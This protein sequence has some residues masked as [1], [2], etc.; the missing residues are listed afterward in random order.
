MTLPD[1]DKLKARVA[2][3][4]A[5]Q[6]QQAPQQ[7]TAPA[8]AA[9]AGPASR[10][11]AEPGLDDGA[12]AELRRLPLLDIYRRWFAPAAERQGGGDEVNVSCFNTHFHRG[13]DSNPQLGF[14]TAKNTYYCHACG[15]TGDIID[16]AAIRWGFCDA[17]WQCPDSDVHEAVR[18]AGEELLGMAFR[19]TPAGWQR[20]Q[21]VQQSFAM[22]SAPSINSAPATLSPAAPVQGGLVLGM[23]QPPVT[24]MAPNLSN[25]APPPYTGPRPETTPEQGAISST[26]DEEERIRR[27]NF[28]LKWRD[29]VPQG[30]PLWNYMQIASHDD[31]P[32]EF[33][34]WNFMSLIG[35]AMGRKVFIP[36][37]KPVYGNMLLCL[38]GRTGQGKSRSES[39]INELLRSAMPFD[40]ADHLTNGVKV[41]KNPGSGE[42]LA[43]IFKHEVPNPTIPAQR[44]KKPQMLVNPSVK[45]LVRWPEMATM[46]GKSAGKGSIVQT[47]MID[48]YDCPDT[49]GGGSMTNGSYE[50]KNPFGSVTTTTQLSAARR[51]V[52]KDD[53][54]SGFLN[55]W[56][57]VIGRSKEFDPW[58]GHINIA[59]VK[60]DVELLVKWVETKYRTT[61]GWHNL[62]DDARQASGEFLV[63]RAHPLEADENDEM[64][65]RAV[66]TF[67]KLI[68][69]F[70][71]N[72]MEEVV[73]IAAVDQAKVAFEYLVDCMKHMGAR[74]TESDYD[75]AIN[76]VMNMIIDSGAEGVQGRDMKKSL[77]R[78]LKLP[79]EDLDK[80]ISDME[81]TGRIQLRVIPQP[82]GRVGA[83]KKRYFLCDD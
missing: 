48:L 39:Y 28:S 58:G 65:R 31:S 27:A 5:E 69:L 20:I 3:L 30:T 51:L 62:D 19:L 78:K 49:I 61:G 11:D 73:S 7:P 35:L 43:S 82:A 50:A 9:P 36:D 40:E 53:A 52:T 60:H 33:H 57:F 66:L 59:P 63:N 12:K 41:V 80:M 81:K 75:V 54:A 74:I 46:I 77:K 64:L 37:V 38:I 71:A 1:P 79:T 8:P 23:F 72:M 70:S 26:D 25:L 2:E 55:R 4:L 45:A 10:V 29:F 15:V 76:H 18:Y 17:N 47:T 6:A 13:G 56:W 34:F 24:S 16:L 83:P 21:P 14:N 22:A 42:Y 67:K 32:E 44:G 68:L